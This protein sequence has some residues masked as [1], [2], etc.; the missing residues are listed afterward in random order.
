[1]KQNKVLSSVLL[2][3]NAIA[4]VN[5]FVF[6]MIGANLGF[7]PTIFFIITFWALTTVTG[8]LF[9][10]VAL[11]LKEQAGGFSSMA[12][13]TLGV[14]GKIAV[15]LSCPLLL[16]AFIASG[17]V[18]VASLPGFEISGIQLPGWSNVIILGL[19][20][21][22]IIICGT[23]LVD[24]FNRGLTVIKG[25][26]LFL[27]CVFLMPR[28]N[29]NVGPYEYLHLGVVI[30]LLLS[31]FRLH[32]II[33]RMCN[34]IGYD[35]PAELR[36][37]VIVGSTIA[38]A[39]L[40]FLTLVIMAAGKGGEISASI[41]DNK[42]FFYGANGFYNVALTASFVM[43]VL[44]LFDFLADGF[45]RQDNKFGRLQ[46]IL[47]VFIPAIIFGLF[48]PRGFILVLKYAPVFTAIFMIIM[49]ALMAYVVRSKSVSVVQSYQVFGGNLLLSAIMLAGVFLAA[50][51]FVCPGFF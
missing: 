14:V 49:P 32:I 4:G 22:G 27:V 29:L 28:M 47:L 7:I 23:S 12:G 40:L 26:C 1:M 45:K 17:V 44:G 25:S 33:P 6:P 31:G 11:N 20:V 21:G 50:L 38:S 39:V 51:P 8:L 2:I 9:L 5:I 18:S 43:T 35:K 46:T 37:S 16:Y 42:W 34:Y 30:P 24:L 15:W 3:I 13:K 36:R 41:V 19:I 48:Y 10:E